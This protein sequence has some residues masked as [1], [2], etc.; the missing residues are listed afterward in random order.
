MSSLNGSAVHNL[1]LAIISTTLGM[2][3]EKQ[4]LLSNETYTQVG[5]TG[6]WLKAAIVFID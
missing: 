4:D 2:S 5:V 1:L 6:I 3:T